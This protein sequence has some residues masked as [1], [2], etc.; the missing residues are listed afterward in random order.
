MS[1]GRRLHEEGHLAR[2]AVEAAVLL[3]QL[4]QPATEKAKEAEDWTCRYKEC[5]GKYTDATTS[6]A[7][8]KF[9]WGFCSSECREARKAA[10]KAPPT[11]CKHGRQKSRCKDCGTGYCQHGRQKHQCKDCGTGHCQ[12]GRQKHQCKG[13]RQK[14]KAIGNRQLRLYTVYKRGCRPAGG[15]RGEDV[16]RQAA[17]RRGAPCEGCG[18]G[19]GATGAA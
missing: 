19:S 12:H 1:A 14:A 18:G 3:E 4:E 10:K 5:N 9:N 2:D 17:P 8:S 13:C 11:Q 16:G 6:G 7:S 15:V